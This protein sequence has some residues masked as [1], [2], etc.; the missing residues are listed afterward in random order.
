M[1]I[2]KTIELF[3]RS[4][5]TIFHF[6]L[7][8]IQLRTYDIELLTPDIELLTYD[9]QLLT[10]DIQLLTSDIELLTY[11]IQLLTIDIQLLTSD[12]PRSPEVRNVPPVWRPSHSGQVGLQERGDRLRQ[13]HR[14][15]ALQPGHQDRDA[16]PGVST[17]ISTYKWSRL[18]VGECL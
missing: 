2:L 13:L 15:Q 10:S 5:H 3:F 11:D 6:I 16:I 4:T 18:Y 17:I 8:D 12:I 1:P 7:L 14:G 9:I